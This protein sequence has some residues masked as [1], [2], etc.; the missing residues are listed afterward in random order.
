MEDIQL[1]PLQEAA[2]R[3]YVEQMQ[4]ALELGQGKVEDRDIQKNTSLHW[5]AAGGHVEAVEFLLK[6]GSL[7]NDVNSWGDTPLHK[8]AWKGHTKVC[9][10]LLDHG[11]G[12]SRLM[13]NQKG[14]RPIDLARVFEVKRLV[15]P[16]QEDQEDEEFDQEDEDSD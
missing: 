6:L 9:Q 15:S 5:A 4:E 2:K 12:A 7:P 11:A 3:G 13:A 1:N 16:P 14:E 8:A 10:V